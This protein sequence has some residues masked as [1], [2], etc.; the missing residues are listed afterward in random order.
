MLGEVSAGRA[1]WTC[2]QRRLNLCSRRAAD[3]VMPLQQARRWDRCLPSE[4]RR[5]TSDE[6]SHAISGLL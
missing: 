1:R 3:D 4:L 2:G 5:Q 6:H